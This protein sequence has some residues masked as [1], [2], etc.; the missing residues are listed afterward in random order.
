MIRRILLQNTIWL[1][2]LAVILFV[3]A[4]DWSWPQ[5]WAFMIENAVGSVV[6]SFWLLKRDPALLEQ[7]MSSPLRKK[8]QRPRDR[9]LIALLGIVYL[10]WIVTMGVDGHRFAADTNP[11][12]G[13]ALGLVAIAGCFVIVMLTFRYN[14][15]AVPQVR[16][17]AE[18]A[19]TVVSDGPYR[20]VRHPMY[21]GALLLFI[22]GPMLLGSQWALV[23]SA[24]MIVLLILRI[25]GEERVL[26]Q[27]LPGYEAYTQKVKYRLFPGLW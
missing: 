12:W 9:L 2:I 18:R 7:R 3:S 10:G 24:L 22:G 17:Q 26:L 27:D 6:I 19:Q 16:V 4:D 20:Y 1:V 15:F 8:D 21:S 14:S 13:Q 23:G 11:L 5:G 25:Q